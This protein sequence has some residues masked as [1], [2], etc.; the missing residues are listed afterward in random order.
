MWVLVLF[1]LPVRTKSERKRATGF[2]KALLEDGFT[3][4]QY[5]V[6]M[7]PCPSDE[8][9][10]THRR[11]IRAILPVRGAVRIISITDRQFSKILCFNGKSRESAEAMPSQLEFF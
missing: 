5:S 4:M 6:Y 8:N 7:R 11:R 1:D 9:A 2:R 10:E 3:M